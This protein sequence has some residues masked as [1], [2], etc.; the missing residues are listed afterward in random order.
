MNQSKHKESLQ[1]SL[2]VFPF[3][4]CLCW[5]LLCCINYVIMTFKLELVKQNV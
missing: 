4:I 3:E 1:R 5:S 2:L